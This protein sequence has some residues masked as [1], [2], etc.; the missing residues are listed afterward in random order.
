MEN[1]EKAQLKAQHKKKLESFFFKVA[2]LTSLIKHALRS[3]FEEATS[4]YS[5]VTT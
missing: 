2:R 3:Q 1:E 5:T 4:A